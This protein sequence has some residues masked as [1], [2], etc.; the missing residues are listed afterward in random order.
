MTYSGQHDDSEHWSLDPL[1]QDPTLYSLATPSPPGFPSFHFAEPMSPGSP[2]PYEHASAPDET[3]WSVTDA[4]SATLVHPATFPDQADY[5][6]PAGGEEWHPDGLSY[7][8]P[9]GSWL[10]DFGLPE[11]P[12][13][14]T[15]DQPAH[16]TSPPAPTISTAAQLRT[17]SQIEQEIA[18][19]TRGDVLKYLRKNGIDVRSANELKNDQL[20]IYLRAEKPHLLDKC[21]L[22]RNGDPRGLSSK[23]LP[24]RPGRYSDAGREAHGRG[25][26]KRAAERAAE[27]AAAREAGERAATEDGVDLSIHTRGAVASFMRETENSKVY[28][29]G[30][31]QD[32]VERYAVAQG[33]APGSLKLPPERKTDTRLIYV[34]QA[35][36]AASVAS[37]AQVRSGAGLAGSAYSAGSGPSASAPA[38]RKGKGPAGRGRR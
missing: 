19:I 16:F 7:A 4:A 38:D 6:Y 27:Q 11:S 32:H 26:A 30:V 24:L 8:T 13:P 18:G 15:P 37:L 2:M 33:L 36:R 9:S 10:P 35:A 23:L 25:A 1:Y 21:R 17:Q 29:I 20:T 34:P 28:A 14:P 31:D 3:Q 22:S 5:G 12:P